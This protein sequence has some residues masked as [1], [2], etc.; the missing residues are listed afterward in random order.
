MNPRRQFVKWL[1][2]CIA[3]VMFIPGC[4]ST[5]GSTKVTP[6]EARAIA[7]EAYIYGF[8]MVDSYRIQYAYFV[9]R[10]N[11]EYK[12]PYNQLRNIARVFTPE[13]KAVQTPNSDTPYSILGMDL[14]SEP[15]VISVPDVKDGRYYSIQ[16]IDAYT[17]NFDY[18]GT[19]STGSEPGNYLIAGP[20][21]KGPIPEGIK[22]VIKSETELVIAIYR[23]QLFNPADLENVKAV[24]A[25]YKA[26]PLSAFLGQA[27]PQAAAAINFISPL[28]PEKQKTSLDF[29]NILNF[30][31]KY[32]PINS[33]EAV[34]MER[35]AKIG[36]GGNK[37]FDTAQMTPEMRSAIHQGMQDAWQELADF[38]KKVDAKELTSGELFGSR[39]YLQNKYIYRM[40]GAV[41]GIYGNSKEEAMYPVYTLDSSGKAL[42]GAR[43][44][45]LRFAPGQLPPVRAFWSLTMYELPASLLVANPLNRYLINSPMLPQLKKDKDGGLTLHIQKDSPGKSL[46]PNWLPAPGGPFFMVLRLYVPADEAIS[47]KWS[48]PAL[49]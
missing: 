15:I 19:R 18:I 32:C 46:E 3:V 10:D 42:N 7:K 39:S 41:I 28:S 17:H 48:A 6:D 38:K 43:K 24:Q 1:L 20:G 8:P 31:L 49:K 9:N 36:V 4:L 14:R 12:G 16:L 44:Y 35:L 5:A 26:Q 22:K 2:P 45:T 27:T 40:G 21:W 34:L 37:A 30:T 33:S 29:F 13:D 11:P 23:T 47:G 25:A